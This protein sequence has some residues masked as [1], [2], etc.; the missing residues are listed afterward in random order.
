[1][2]RM[3]PF[4]SEDAYITFRYARSLLSGAGLV[5]NPGEAVMGFTSAPWTLWCAAGMALTGDPVLWTRVSSVVADLLAIALGARLL[6]RHA[7]RTAAFAW[8]AVFALWP[9]FSALAMSGMETGP[10]L[11]LMLLSGVLLAAR[12]ALA[13]PVTAL[14]ALWRPEGLVAA[15]VLLLWGSWRDRAVAVV[16][17]AAGYGALALGFGSPLPNSLF[18]KARLYGTPGPLAGIHWWDWLSPVPPGRWPTP[19]DTALLVPLT[20]VAAPAFVAGLAHLARRR[21]SALA[22]VAA[23]GLVVWLGYVALGVPYFWWYLAVPLGSISLVAAAG[24]PRVV[25][26]RAVPLA[27][28]AFLVGVWMVARP[29]YLGRAQNEYYAFHQAGAYLREAARPGESALLEPIGFI[30]Y[31]APVRVIDEI[32]LVSPEVARR[33][34]EGPGWYADVVAARTPEWLV[35]RRGT[36]RAGVAFAGA[37]APFRSAAERDSVFAGY[38]LRSSFDEVSGERAL[39]VWRRR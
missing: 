30:G 25:R 19:G 20:V 26:G 15:V 9:Y 11:P 2:W 33:R 12:H 39:E 37:G 23:A 4:A 22:A 38:E 8:G 5:Y 28:L 1:M 34:L 27:M 13:G 7:S 24:L 31:I 29:V 17:A 16:L 32:G 21:D 18:A 36:R 35:V 14:L 10:M 6:E 3:I